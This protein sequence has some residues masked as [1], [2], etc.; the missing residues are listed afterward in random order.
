MYGV[1]RQRWITEKARADG[2]VEVADIARLLDV[3]METVRRDL[4]VLERRGLIQRVH[5]GAVPTQRLGTEVV[6]SDRDRR[7]RAEKQLIAQASLRL[8]TGAAVIYL[9]EGSTVRMLAESWHPTEP[10]TVV[11][12][13]LDT[14]SMLAARAHVTVLL[15]GGRIRPVTT[16]TVEHWATDM[17]AGITLDLAVMGTNGASATRGLTC[18]DAAVSAVKAAAMRSARRRVVLADS[19]KFATDSLFT[20][21]RWEPIESLVTDRGTPS[22]ALSAISALGVEIIRAGLAEETEPGLHRSDGAATND[23]GSGLRDA[24]GPDGPAGSLTRTA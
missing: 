23:L 6:L 22:A 17:L 20:F 21:A 1:E 9:D 14:A 12:N 2:R 13:A 11:T 10:V 3:A 24:A 19:S 5:G 18:P 16:A 15:L 7:H 8:L 4:G